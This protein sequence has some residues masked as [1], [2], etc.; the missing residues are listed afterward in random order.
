MRPSIP[1]SLWLRVYIHTPTCTRVQMHASMQARV[2][3]C[4]RKYKCTHR[5]VLYVCRCVC[6]LRVCVSCVC[7]CVSCVCVCVGVGWLCVCVDVCI[8][9]HICVYVF[10]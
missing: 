10:M 2:H 6:V 4:A 9:T 1:I 8:Y 5:H 7:V 3:G